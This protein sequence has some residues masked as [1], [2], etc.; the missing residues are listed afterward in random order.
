MKIAGARIRVFDEFD[1]LDRD[2][3]KRRDVTNVPHCLECHIVPSVLSSVI[4]FSLPAER[5]F[6]VICVHPEG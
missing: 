3:G 5:S 4:H 6:I 2:F 1:D